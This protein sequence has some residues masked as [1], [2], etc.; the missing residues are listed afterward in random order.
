GL[1]PPR[2]RQEVASPGSRTKPLLHPEAGL[3]RLRSTSLAVAD[4][5]EARIVVYTP[6]DEEARQRLA[7]ARRR[8]GAWPAGRSLNDRQRYQ[9][10]A[11]GG[12]VG[13]QQAE[14]LSV[15]TRPAGSA[16]TLHLLRAAHAP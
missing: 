12:H 13:L 7:L 10:F 9:G 4:M 11:V 1:P 16:R 8:G 2:R 6:A 14:H 3:L 15:G 5:P